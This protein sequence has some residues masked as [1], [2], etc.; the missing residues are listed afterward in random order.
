MRSRA[1]RSQRAEIDNGT[2]PGTQAVALAERGFTVTATDVSPAALEFVSRRA[3]EG[4]VKLTLMQDDVLETHLEGPFDAAFD[5]GCFHVI[6][7]ELRG[8][9]VRNMHGLLTPGAYLLVKTFSH[10][11]P[12]ERGPHRFTSDDLQSIFASGADAFEIVEIRDTV[13]QGQL[14]PWPKALFATMRRPG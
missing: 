1:T 10:L 12:G 7:P 11:Q 14:E 2:G 3:K 8:R 13:Y 6:A 9:Y 4:G 5:R